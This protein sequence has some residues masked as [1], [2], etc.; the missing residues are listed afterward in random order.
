MAKIK[1]AVVW[2]VV[3][4]LVT[5]S[6]DEAKQSETDKDLNKLEGTWVLAAVEF[7]GKAPAP[8]DTT[9]EARREWIIN[10]KKYTDGQV[11]AAY[12]KAQ[13]YLRINPSK[14]PKAID[15][16]DTANFK[17]ADTSHGI[18]ELDGDTLKT[19]FAAKGETRPTEFKTKPKG[20]QAIAHWKKK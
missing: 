11:G 1:A 19:Y 2:A 12:K 8:Q 7:K 13:G 10:G 5:A 18:Y 15:I 3:G 17:A 9:S 6:A 4:L 16:S 20:L 14:T